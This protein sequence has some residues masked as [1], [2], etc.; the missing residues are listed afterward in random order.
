MGLEYNMQLI[1]SGVLNCVQLVGVASSL[2]S[3]DRIGR[4]PLLLWG[5]LIMFVSH[6]IISILVGKYSHDW[7]SYRPEGWA[8][9]AMLLV[10]MLGFGASWVSY[11]VSWRCQH[12]LMMSNRDR[13]HGQC[14]LKCSRPPFVLRVS[15]E[16]SAFFSIHQQSTNST[17]LSTSCNWLFNFIIGLITP[18]L[19][20]NTGFGA[21]V[22]F[23]VFCLLSLF[24]VYFFVPETAGKTLEEMDNVFGDDSSAGEE[25]R[26][27][28][29]ELAIAARISGN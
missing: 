19:V 18:P 9:V 1:M 28:R 12:S 6:L 22:F 11:L 23:A 29:I 2:W 15:R 3:M 14:H 8:S 25:A 20:E 27:E 24:W 7:P 21:Y 17:R 4:K 10:Y 26:R 16:S 5:S 13:Y